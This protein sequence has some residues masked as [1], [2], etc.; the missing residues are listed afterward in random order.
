MTTREIRAYE[1]EQ[2]DVILDSKGRV[3]AQVTTPP[4]ERAGLIHFDIQT[5]SGSETRWTLQRNH[6]ITVEDR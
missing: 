2:G 5:A 4:F 6:E 1:L 3:A